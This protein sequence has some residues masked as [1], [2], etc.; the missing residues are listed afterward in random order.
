MVDVH[1]VADGPGSVILAGVLGLGIRDGLGL[2]R[3]GLGG[4]WHTFPRAEAL[5]VVGNAT[6]TFGGP[7][8]ALLLPVG[9]L[10][11]PPAVGAGLLAV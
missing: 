2:G 6:G 4:E 8:W 1:Q 10:L 3:V 11:G 7:C 9:V 5:V